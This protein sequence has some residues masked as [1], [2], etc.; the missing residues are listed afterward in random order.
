MPADVP[1]GQF[2]S[3]TLYS[4]N[5]RRPYDNGGTE[6]SDVSLDSRMEQLK[7]NDDGSI[8][9]YVGPEALQGLEM[10]HLKTVTNDGWFIYFRLYAPKE[11][12]FD[13]SFSLPDF[14]KLN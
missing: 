13:K 9:L 10:N 3:L 12:F 4:E 14:V 2:W 11:A 8:D 7:Y 5:T 1:V 6:I